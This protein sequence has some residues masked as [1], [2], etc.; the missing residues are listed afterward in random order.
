MLLEPSISLAER[1]R[2][3]VA[4]HYFPLTYVT[5]SEW[6]QTALS[7]FNAFLVDHVACERKA[8]ATA[9]S[10]VGKFSDKPDFVDALIGL[11]RDEM[12]HFHQ[13]YRMM[14]ARGLPLVGNEEDDYAK[15]LLALCR[16]GSKNDI[17]LDRVL[18]FG[19]IEARG[20]ERFAMVSDEMRRRPELE[21]YAP[22]YERLAVEEAKHFGLFIKYAQ[23]YCGEAVTRRRSEEMIAGEDE[24][25]R[26]LPWRAAVH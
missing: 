11:A 8:V 9:L 13:V 6:V 7:D 21:A 1:A 23:K 12:E 3:L 22:F 15:G 20:V 10:F 2:R 16:N 18:V 17:F 19:I 24:L 14:Q 25:L 5:P 26:R 4:E